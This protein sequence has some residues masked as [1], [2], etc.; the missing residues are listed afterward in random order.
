[1]AMKP[2]PVLCRCGS[3]AEFKI[4]SQ[5]SDGMTEELKTY[6]ICC[7]KC[8]KAE[9]AEAKRRQAAC[10]LQIGE[11]LALP[12]VFEWVRDTRDTALTR[13]VELEL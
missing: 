3:A 11:A 4:A 9:Y 6:A 12:G 10:P 5:W 13:R 2:Y 7:A 8:L 1:M